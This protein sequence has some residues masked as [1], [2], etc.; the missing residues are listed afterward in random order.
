MEH[1]KHEEATKKATAKKRVKSKTH[2]PYTAKDM[3]IP[4]GSTESVT[5]SVTI[6]EAGDYTAT[7]DH[8]SQNFN[9]VERES[10]QA[11]KTGYEAILREYQLVKSEA[12]YYRI[13]ADG[14][15][16]LSEREYFIHQS[17]NLEKRAMELYSVY[18]DYLYKN[19]VDPS[20]LWGA[21]TK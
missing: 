15:S 14:C 3:F 11:E 1:H 6:S 10:Q 4:A 2:I 19:Y 12:S 17:D 21:S 8:L 13:V 20:P 7:V 5:Y 9:V 18:L 16:D